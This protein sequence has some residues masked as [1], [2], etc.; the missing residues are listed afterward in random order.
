MLRVKLVN[1]INT[2]YKTSKI[3]TKYQWSAQNANSYIEKN[4]DGHVLCAEKFNIFECWPLDVR[5]LNVDKSWTLALIN[6]TSR[7]NTKRC[8]YVRML[9][10]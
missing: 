8:T 10:G 2:K 1:D 9:M 5:M 7:L 4:I 6:T 3:F